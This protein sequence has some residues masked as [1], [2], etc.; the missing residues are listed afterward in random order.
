[1]L[2]QGA[3]KYQRITRTETYFVTCALNQPFQKQ[4][5]ATSLRKVVR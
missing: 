1:M 4:N 5:I 3:R 2:F